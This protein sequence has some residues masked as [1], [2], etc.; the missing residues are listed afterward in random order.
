MI[1]S[2]LVSGLIIEGQ[3]HKVKPAPLRVAEAV[4][5][6]AQARDITLSLD[7][8]VYTEKLDALHRPEMFI[9][10]PTGN[11]EKII[12]SNKFVVYEGDQ[13]RAYAGGGNMEEFLLALGGFVTKVAQAK[14]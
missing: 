12:W 3:E 9:G 14:R 1:E 13:I 5:A 2:K 7:K 8:M 10:L 6:L 11:E 4:V